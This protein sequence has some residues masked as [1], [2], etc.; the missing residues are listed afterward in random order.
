[1]PRRDG[2]YWKGTRG[3]R[4]TKGT[5]PSGGQ[6]AATPCI[7]RVLGHWGETRGHRG[8]WGHRGRMG[9]PTGCCGSDTVGDGGLCPNGYGV[10]LLGTWGQW[11]FSMG[12]WGRWRS[13]HHLGY[14]MWGYGGSG[15]PRGGV[16]DLHWGS[17]PGMW[18]H[19]GDLW[20]CGA[21]GWPC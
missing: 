4:D 2:T 7:M 5:E 19:W 10:S 15:G 14:R 20:G 8:G 18:R 3:Q 9:T 12:K 6:W 13:L 1:M 11:G 21:I 16:E 17:S